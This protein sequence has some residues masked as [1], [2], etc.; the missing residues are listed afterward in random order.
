MNVHEI[1]SKSIL[2]KQKK[3]ESWF[4]SYYGMNLYRGCT[5]NCSYCD[6]RAEG[7]YVDGEFGCDISVKTNALDLLKRELDPSR[8]RKPMKRSFILLGGGVGDSYQPLEKQYKLARGALEL[9]EYFNHPVHVLTK[10]TLVERDMDILL[11]IHEKQRTLLSMSFSSVDEDVSRIFE[12]GVPSPLKRLET[13]KKFKAQG[14]ICGM[15]LLP[16]IPFITDSEE[17]IERSVKAAADAGLDYIHFGGMT[18]K[19]GRQRQYFESVIEKHYPKELGK[20]RKIYKGDRWGQAIGKYYDWI[21]AN[22]LKAA[23]EHNIPLRVPKPVFDDILDETDRVI[24][25][26]EQMDY[27]M[28]LKGK[29]GPYGYAAWSLAKTGEPVSELKD[30]LESIKGINDKAA[31]VIREIL[32]TGNAKAYL[33][34]ME[35]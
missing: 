2:R 23:K 19:D 11:R 18:L 32:E 30:K 1:Q 14:V 3:I 34:S 5:H 21:H 4:L 8:K 6:G 35:L 17:Q 25:M 31:L 28:R 12:P 7:Y 26:L 29:K 15:Y 33:Q 20:Y 22:L 9:I 10:S 16:V 24:V 27:M 13:L